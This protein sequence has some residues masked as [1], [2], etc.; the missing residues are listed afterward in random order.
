MPSNFDEVLGFKSEVIVSLEAF[1]AAVIDA[2]ISQSTTIN[3]SI[4]HFMEVGRKYF[5]FTKRSQ[6][7]WR[8]RWGSLI[9]VYGAGFASVLSSV[10]NVRSHLKVN[11]ERFVIN[12]SYRGF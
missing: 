11:L 12:F 3:P 7:P 2:M 1:W 10:Y 9:C 8:T 4:I 6:I 5:D